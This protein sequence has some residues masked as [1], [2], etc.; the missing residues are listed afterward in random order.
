MKTK[1]TKEILQSAIDKSLSMSECIRSLGLKNTGGNYVHIKSLVKFYE[2]DVSHFTGKLWNKGQ[3]AKTNLSIASAAIKNSIPNDIIFIANSQPIT[4]SRITKRLLALGWEYKCTLCEN[5]GVW[6][7]KPITLHLDH[8]NGVHNDNRFENL[9]FLCPNCHQQTDTWGNKKQICPSG[10]TA[11][12]ESLEVSAERL[13]GSTPV[14][15]TKFRKSKGV[16]KPNTR[17]VIRPN[18]DILLKEL[19]ESNY[20]QMGKKYGV[21]DNA[22]RKWLK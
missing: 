20:T 10:E 16:A 21:S 22:I 19:S 15:D 3:T 14:S 17:K 4:G 7:N 5:P 6:M 11:N 12:T 2:L 1:Y 18:K 8:I 9:R 13:A